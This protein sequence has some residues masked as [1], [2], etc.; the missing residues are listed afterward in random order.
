MLDKIFLLARRVFMRLL[1]LM[2][3]LG[4]FA[5]LVK[6]IPLEP[7]TAL[8]CVLP[9]IGI[10]VWLVVKY[11]LPG[12]GDLAAST[13]YSS[14]ISTDEEVMVEAARR[15][16]A[17]GDAKGA[18]ASLERHRKENAAMV[19]PWLMEAGLLNEMRR[20]AESAEL[21]QEALASRRWRKEDRA[22]FLYKIGTVYANM[23]NNPD[24]ARQYL[25]QA[26]EDYPN[27]AYGRSAAD[28]LDQ[29]R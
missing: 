24:K 8:V 4:L 13:L 7:L 9:V 21:L 25:E 23:L 10:E 6:V 28:K 27:T 3:P 15:M 5:F 19:R 16:L 20:H 12:M 1:L 26:A 18:L 11:I 22:L 2:L 29:L 17:A 14:N